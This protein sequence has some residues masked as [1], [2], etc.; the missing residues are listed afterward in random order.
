MSTS[1][2][3]QVQTNSKQSES[4]FWQSWTKIRQW[5]TGGALSARRLKHALDIYQLELEH[6]T[7]YQKP[8]PG[9]TSSTDP[10]SSTNVAKEWW[11]TKSEDLI[12]KARDVNEKDP[13]LGWRYFKAATR[14]EFHGLTDENLGVRARVIYHEGK[15]KLGSWRK[16]LNQDLLGEG[17][18]EKFN[19]TLFNNPNN[20]VNKDK[21]NELIY[22]V[23]L[24]AQA[25][26]EHQDNEYQKIELVQTQ[27]ANF[28]VLSVVIVGFWIAYLFFLPNITAQC[29]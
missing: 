11:Y 29:W 16:D 12:K 6:L 27:L 18:N 2:E 7:H 22:R 21:E 10:T 15:K 17:K 20:N 14:L 26:H 8:G 9:G 23:T 3:D 4:W 28:S 25:L 13:E 5:W 19:V 24:A 1:T